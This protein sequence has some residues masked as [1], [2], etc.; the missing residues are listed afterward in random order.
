MCAKVEKDYENFV[1]E[2][3]GMHHIKVDCDAHPK[4]KRYFDTRVEPS[5][6]ILVNGGEVQRMIGYNFI[7]IS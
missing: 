7:K 1:S 5:F 4:V 2:N 3:S 6:L